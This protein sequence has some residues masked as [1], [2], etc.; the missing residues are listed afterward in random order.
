M[1]VG[2]R[3]A[4]NEDGLAPH[5]PLRP[6]NGCHFQPVVGDLDGPTLLEKRNQQKYNQHN[7]QRMDEDVWRGGRTGRDHLHDL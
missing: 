1:A 7:N 6:Q 5:G 3:D 4:G 2:A